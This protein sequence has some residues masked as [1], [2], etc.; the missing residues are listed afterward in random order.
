MARLAGGVD[1]RRLST[2]SE[3][4][5]DGSLSTVVVP[6]RI[7]PGVSRPYQP[8]PGPALEG[9]LRSYPRRRAPER[10]DGRFSEGTPACARWLFS[11]AGGGVAGMLPRRTARTRVDVRDPFLTASMVSPRWFSHREDSMDRSTHAVRPRCGPRSLSATGRCP[12]RS[13]LE[14]VCACPAA[15]PRCRF[16]CVSVSMGLFGAAVC[17]STSANS[18]R[19]AAAAAPGPEPNL[20]QPCNRVNAGL[21]PAPRLCRGP[22]SNEEEVRCLMFRPRALPT[23]RR[24][25]PAARARRLPSAASAALSLTLLNRLIGEGRFPRF[26]ALGLRTSGLT[27]HQLD[28]FFAER[29]SAR[30][31][32]PLLPRGAVRPRAGACAARHPTT[33]MPVHAA[34]TSPPQPPPTP[35]TSPASRASP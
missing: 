12:A 23:H 14:L 2:G 31:V 22:C 18:P 25:C 26:T 24:R 5:Y 28:A 16:R 9:A 35:T 7:R 17:R 13:C 4:V 33:T 32:R 8:A 3:C 19:R 20:R 30:V 34:P 10:F 6:I 21:P 1:W 29:L 11:A 27:E 15:P